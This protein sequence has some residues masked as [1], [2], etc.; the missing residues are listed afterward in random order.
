MTKNILLFF[1]YFTVFDKK[2]NKTPLFNEK[3]DPNEAIKAISYGLN[4]QKYAKLNTELNT[5][6]QT[7]HR[8]LNIIRI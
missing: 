5:K 4:C 6:G 2:N 1:K 7:T 8:I 3:P